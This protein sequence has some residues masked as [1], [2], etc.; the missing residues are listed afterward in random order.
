MRDCTLNMEQMDRLVHSQYRQYVFDPAHAQSGS[1]PIRL[2]V[3]AFI[4]RGVS[5]IQLFGSKDVSMAE[6]PLLINAA[7]T[8]AIAGLLG[9][10]ADS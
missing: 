7:V 8:G 4:L 3:V 9:S 1:F 5:L 10:T 2:G 6:K